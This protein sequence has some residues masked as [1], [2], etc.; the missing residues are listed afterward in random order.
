MILPKNRA[1]KIVA[2]PRPSIFPEK[3][4]NTIP[5]IA[6]IISWYILIHPNSFCSLFDRT[7]TNP[8]GALGTK[9]Q[10]INI[11]TPNP[12]KNNETKSNKSWAMKFVGFT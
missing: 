4:P 11:T 10:L 7:S 1:A 12:I 2:I 3:Y 9:S 5:N 8:S 6:M